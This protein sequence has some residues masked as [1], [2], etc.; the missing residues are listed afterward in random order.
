[1]TIYNKNFKDKTFFRNSW[2]QELRQEIEGP[3]AGQLELS[4]VDRY[5]KIAGAKEELSPA[6][7]N[8]RDHVFLILELKETIPTIHV[9]KD[10]SEV[11]K[12][13]VSPHSKQC[14]PTHRLL[15]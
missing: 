7:I 9:Q 2:G 11:K 3:Q 4:P 8:Y 15:C 1:M 5:S 12:E 14:Q 6:Q 10:S 13:G